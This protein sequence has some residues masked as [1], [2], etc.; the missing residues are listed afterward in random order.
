[1]G[2]TEGA[3]ASVSPNGPPVPRSFLG[4]LR[5]FGPGFVVVLTWLGAGDVVDMAVAGANYGYALMWVLVVAVFMRFVFVSLVARYQL[6]NQWGE[7]VLDGLARLHPAYAPVIFAATVVMGHVYESYM[8]VGAGEAC[9]N[10]FRAGETWQWALFLNGAALLLVFRPAYPRLERVFKLFLGLLAVSFLGSAFWV[11]FNPAGL[12]QGLFRFEMPGARGRFEPWLV[13]VAMIGAVGG[14]LMNLAYPYFLEAKGWRG[15]RYR[16]VQLYDLLLA[17]AVMVVLNLAVWT[18]G[19]ELLYPDRE[20]RELDDLP[21]LLSAVLGEGGR[22]LFYLGIF[23]AV[24]TSVLG[25]AAGLACMGSHAW[26]RWRAGRGALGSDYREGP[27][28]RGLVVWCL[29]S[30][31]VWTLPG[32]PDFVTLTLV[33]NGAQVVLVPLLA[34]GLWWITASPRC[35]GPE[36]CN[37]WWENLVMAVLFALAL[38]GAGSAVASISRWL[39]PPSGLRQ[40]LVDREGL[41]GPGPLRGPRR[42]GV[43]PERV[44]GGEAQGEEPHRAEVE[45]AGGDVALPHPGL[46]PAEADAQPAR[47]VEGPRSLDRAADHRGERAAHLGRRDLGGE[48]AEEG[49]L[50]EEVEGPEAVGERAPDRGERPF[51]RDEPLEDGRV[52]A[53]PGEGG[54][55]H[56]LPGRRGRPAGLE[57]VEEHRVDHEAVVVVPVEGGTVAVDPVA[58]VPLGVLAQGVVHPERVP[59]RPQPGEGGLHRRREEEPVVEGRLD[60]PGRLEGPHEVGAHPRIEGG[61]EGPGGAEEGLAEERRVHEGLALPGEVQVVGRGGVHRVGE[62]A[63]GEVGAGGADAPLRPVVALELE[64]GREARE[65][66][67]EGLEVGHRGAAR[68]RRL[69]HRHSGPEG[70]RREVLEDGLGQPARDP[71]PVL[72]IGG[73]PGRVRP[74]LRPRGRGDDGA[75]GGSQESS[76]SGPRGV[77]QGALRECPSL[78]PLPARGTTGRPLLQ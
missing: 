71:D 34:G 63:P 1:M 59:P 16:K 36:H 50:G 20:I 2:F 60:G 29:V 3:P 64:P 10:L 6:C 4:Y 78:Y 25:H 14:S 41:A 37:R 40:G 28:Y 21:R 76:A 7:G 73:G 12:V 42:L 72:A 17:M 8:T 30:P 31:L 46:P 69:F 70:A 56:G 23:A 58:L 27:L 24:Y 15:P 11:G 26:L 49:H 65:Q 18:L 74:R 13:A 61:D 33:A 48:L 54:G 52:A 57:H 75:R 39:V 53:G 62:G 51:R 43:R 47:L 44:G 32:M 22:V 55:P 45:A 5:S 68:P 77:V 66:A 38:Y 9:R 67:A 19:A 35:I